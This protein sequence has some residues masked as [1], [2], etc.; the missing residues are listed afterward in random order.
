MRTNEH[1]IAQ[2]K[3]VPDGLKTM[4]NLD[5][6]ETIVLVKPYVHKEGTL[7]GVINSVDLC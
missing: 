7:Y 3:L 5:E 2:I 1:T 6:D 4:K